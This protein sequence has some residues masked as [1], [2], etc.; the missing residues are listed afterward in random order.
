MAAED[1]GDYIRRITAPYHALNPAP[2][3]THA[4]EPQPISAV[5]P[6]AQPVSE[7][8]PAARKFSVHLTP[9]EVVGAVGSRVKAESLVGHSTMRYILQ[10]EQ[11]APQ[12]R[13]TVR[14]PEPSPLFGDM[15]TGDYEED[16]FFFEPQRPK[17]APIYTGAGAEETQFI[18]PETEPEAEPESESSVDQPTEEFVPDFVQDADERDQSTPVAEKAAP[19]AEEYRG[20]RR[21]RAAIITDFKSATE[22]RAA[23]GRGELPHVSP[24]TIEAMEREE[25]WRRQ[26]AIQ[27]PAATRPRNE[28]A[29]ERGA[30][31]ARERMEARGQAVPVIALD[32]RRNKLSRADKTD[33]EEHTHGKRN[34]IGAITAVAAA[35]VAVAFLGGGGDNHPSTTS[36]TRGSTTPTTPNIYAQAPSGTPDHRTKKGDQP[37]HTKTHMAQAEVAQGHDAHHARQPHNSNHHE[38]RSQPGATAAS[39][40]TGGSSSAPAPNQTAHNGAPVPSTSHHSS[41]SSSQHHSSGGSSSA[42]PASASQLHSSGNAPANMQQSPQPAPVIPTRIVGHTVYYSNGT[43]VPETLG[44]DGVYHAPGGAADVSGSEKVAQLTGGAASAAPAEADTGGSPIAR[45]AS[46]GKPTRKHQPKPEIRHRKTGEP[47][48]GNKEHEDGGTNHPTKVRHVGSK[49]V[50]AVRPESRKIRAKVHL[51]KAVKASEADGGEPVNS[52]KSA[53]WSIGKRAKS[54]KVTLRHSKPAIAKEDG[55]TPVRREAAK[56]SA[57]KPTAVKTTRLRK[58]AS[59]AKKTTTATTVKPKTTSTPK[60]KTRSKRVAAKR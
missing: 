49:A 54:D 50:R 52:G 5:E 25:R 23:F 28:S 10:E 34:A 42:S 7:P 26:Q 31:V 14:Q 13:D 2:E 12:P 45:T 59:A 8:T 33:E 46:R 44:P 35:T 18:E 57:T 19:S 29:S 24:A 40:N 39:A 9:E 3:V 32:S 41:S 56:S 53:N 37:D 17:P 43:Q 38:N 51:R 48:D 15:E 16:S 36:A 11:P 30:R 60:L 6:P 4:V 21:Q 58:A 22:A 27:Q 1:A 20:P 47:E 55:V